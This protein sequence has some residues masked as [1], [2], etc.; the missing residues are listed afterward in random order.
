VVA[1]DVIDDDGIEARRA[2]APP[3]LFLSRRGAWYHD[4]DRVR[5]AGLEGLLFR[6]IARA[7]DG[8]LIVTTG[9]DVLP[10]FAEDA[11]FLVRTLGRAGD[12]LA[13]RLSDESEEAIALRPFVID[14]RGRVRCV[15]KGGR[16]WALLSRS[17]TQLLLELVDDLGRLRTPRGACSLTPTSKTDWASPPHPGA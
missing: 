17:A 2:D 4:G 1:M 12:D 6:S 3:G 15:V 13:L 16:F 5:H 11:P 9:R 8:A 14:D 10:F 7:D